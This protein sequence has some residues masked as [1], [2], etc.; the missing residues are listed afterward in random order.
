VALREINLIPPD[1]AAKRLMVRHLMCWAGCLVLA[2]G[3]ISAARP[4][5]RYM[6][7]AKWQTLSAMKAIPTQL[8]SRIEVLKGL[9]H[10]QEELNQLRSALTAIRSKNP[11]ASPILLKLSEIMND[12]TW[13]VQ[14]SMD[15]DEGQDKGQEKGQETGHE[16]GTNLKLMG[17]ST[18]NE[19]LGDFLNR[20][21]AEQ[22]FKAVAL[23]S[24]GESARE[25]QGQ[26]GA[27]VRGKIRFEITCQVRRR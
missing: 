3:I 5:Q 19:H 23:K 17:F 6:I 27:A 16:R 1:I 13:L 4:V 18:S 20:L 15:A 25:E 22:L 9:Q 24:A 7:E 14:L 2:V 10:D 21:S 12:Q 26:K 8:A 11:P